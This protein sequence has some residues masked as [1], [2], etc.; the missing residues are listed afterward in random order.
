M[1]D[2][3]AEDLL[4][5]PREKKLRKN[6]SKSLKYKKIRCLLQEI[7]TYYKK[8]TI[9]LYTSMKEFGLAKGM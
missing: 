5:F 2:G 3:F 7:C 9:R 4:Y 6:I 1:R 8:E